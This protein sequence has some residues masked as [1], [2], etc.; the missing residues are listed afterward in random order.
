MRTDET[1]G[2]APDLHIDGHPPTAELGGTDGYERGEI[3]GLRVG[4]GEVGRSEIRVRQ[5]DVAIGEPVFF[6]AR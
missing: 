2:L 1:E 4:Q 5:H 6:A 3:A